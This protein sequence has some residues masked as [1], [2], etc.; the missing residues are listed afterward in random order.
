V[1]SIDGPKDSQEKGS[2]S[3]RDG[4]DRKP[5]WH[6]PV[7]QEGEQ[8]HQARDAVG[9]SPDE[10]VRRRESFTWLICG[11]TDLTRHADVHDERRL[12]SILLG[13]SLLK[14]T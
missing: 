11:T 4:G 5:R 7:V 9:L 13:N 12:L 10:P 14:W 2:L 6:N 3:R 1:K 8:K